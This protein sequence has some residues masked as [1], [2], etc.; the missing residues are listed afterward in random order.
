YTVSS[1]LDTVDVTGWY[2][3]PDDSAQ[4]FV[5]GNNAMKR[6]ADGGK[7]WRDFLQGLPEKP[8]IRGLVGVKEGRDLYLYAAVSGEGVYRS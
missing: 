5:G 3:D 6:S 8:D 7:I 1:K 2:I 4:I